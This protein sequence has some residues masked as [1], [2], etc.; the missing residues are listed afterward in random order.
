[1]DGITTYN[2]LMVK[3]ALGTHMVTGYAEDSFIT[4]EEISEE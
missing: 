1:M 2:P 4:I 3:V